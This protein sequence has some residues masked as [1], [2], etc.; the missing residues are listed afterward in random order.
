[1]LIHAAVGLIAPPGEK[2][3]DEDFCGLLIAEDEVRQLALCGCDVRG[4]V[5]N[6]ISFEI[7]KEY[8]KKM[9]QIR[10]VWYVKIYTDKGD[11]K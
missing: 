5:L 7:D 4:E 10:A 8:Y 2:T 6:D 3:Y 9:D 11:S 1:M